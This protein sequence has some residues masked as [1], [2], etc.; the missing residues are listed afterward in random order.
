M[1]ETVLDASAVL[2]YL[3][4]EPG[5]EVVGEVLERGLGVISAVNLSEDKEAVY[6]EAMA[7]GIARDSLNIS[8]LK[9]QLTLSGE[10]SGP[11]EEVKD[12]DYHRSERATGNF[13]RTIR[14]PVEV[15]ADQVAADYKD[16]L[17]SLTL[18][19]AETAKPKQITVK[20][21]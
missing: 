19:K 11:G 7:P 21:G 16:G 8:V 3:Q 9:D 12:T 5:E 4:G 13:L 6:V 17:L 10:K 1:T 2:A 18:P 14:L 15:N 20:T